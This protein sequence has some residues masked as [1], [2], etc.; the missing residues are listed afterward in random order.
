M[1]ILKGR[2]KTRPYGI[3]YEKVCRD[4]RPRVSDAAV[5]I[6]DMIDTAQ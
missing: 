5:R 2:V 3:L 1:N 4:T 6:A